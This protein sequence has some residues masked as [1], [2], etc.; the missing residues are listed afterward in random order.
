VC[1]H[2]TLTAEANNA[3]R[4]I[5]SGLSANLQVIDQVT[6]H[7]KSELTG[8]GVIGLFDY[9]GHHVV[10]NPTLQNDVATAATV[11][12]PDNAHYIA[13]TIGFVAPKNVNTSVG[14]IFEYA[15]ITSSAPFAAP[16]A[17]NPSGAL[18]TKAYSGQFGAIYDQPA[19]AAAIT[20]GMVTGIISSEMATADIQSSLQSAVVAAVVASV[21]QNGTNRT[22]PAHPFN[23][24]GSTTA[25]FQQS[26]G[27]STF[28]NP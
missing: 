7:I 18:T 19:A 13:N 9:I 24:P 1:R 26:T 23:A 5:N 27:A 11:V 22:G 16:S 20:A 17:G 10:E 4:G 6:T 28:S 3:V 25:Q 2:A 8:S 15:Q 14:A 12:D 21:A